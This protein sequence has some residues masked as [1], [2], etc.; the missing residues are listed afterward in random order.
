MTPGPPNA[1]EAGLV[2]IKTVPPGLLATLNYP[3]T[4]GFSI[5]MPLT[6]LWSLQISISGSFDAGLTATITPPADV[7]LTPPAGTLTGQLSSILTATPGA[8]LPIVI[9]GQAGGSRLAASSVS[10]GM[11]V[12]VTWDSGLWHRARRPGHRR[13]ASPAA[14]S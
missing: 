10:F 3:L 8:G 11:G 7:A 1:L 13:P 6:A 14:R 5:T 2:S 4:D 9:L 12:N